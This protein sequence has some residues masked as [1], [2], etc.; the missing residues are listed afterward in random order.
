MTEHRPAMGPLQSAELVRGAPVPTLLD[1]PQVIGVLRRRAHV[2]L[3]S[4][5]IALVAALSYLF[6]A[7][8]QYTA[9]V[10][11][12]IDTRGQKILDAYDVVPNL[13]SETEPIESQIEVLRSRRIAER[14]LSYGNR[15]VEETALQDLLR[16]LRI[17][18]QGLSTVIDVSLK[19]RDPREAARM[20]N[21]LAD[22]FLA[23]QVATKQ[24]TIRQASKW[25]AARVAD[26]GRELGAAEKQVTALRKQSLEGGA[27]REVTPGLV[28]LEATLD[29][30]RQLYTSLLRRL[31]ETRMQEDM[32]FP[33]A[34]IIAYATPPLHPSAPIWS[35][36][37]ALAALA[38]LVIG[39][40]V[41]LIQEHRLA[42]PPN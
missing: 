27:S 20:V 41:A 23:D 38:G 8:P 37:L 22:G 25:L 6:L 10:R 3:A 18:R 34:R 29:A 16:R 42:T 11:L 9:T 15:P 19:G 13:G 30:D 28:E 14:I 1:F 21:A 32:Q 33:D 31:K 5:L 24:A 7:E 4:I 39:I 12:A 35:F 40:V 17:E 2:I 26:L 36:T